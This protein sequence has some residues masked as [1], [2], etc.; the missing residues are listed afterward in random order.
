MKI[1]VCY[2]G[3]EA[4]KKALAVAKTHAKTFKGVVHIVTSL[5]EGVKEDSG[6]KASERVWED[7]EDAQRKLD[8]VRALFEQQGLSCQT[9]VSVRGLTPG[10]D[11][12]QFARDNNIDE[13]I[14]GVERKSKLGKLLF[15]STAQFV[16]L[17][18]PCPVLTVK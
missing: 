10:E 6:P 13:I 8:E 5:E 7:V 1:Q 16:I 12:V 3:S 17:E 14:I 9:H 15:G 2:D 4:A 11:L 18:A